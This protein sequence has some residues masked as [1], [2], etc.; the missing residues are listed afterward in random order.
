VETPWHFLRTEANDDLY[1][2][3]PDVYLCNQKLRV[4]RQVSIISIK[5]NN[6]PNHNQMQ[7]A[8]RE[9]EGANKRLIASIRNITMCTALTGFLGKEIQMN[10]FTSAPTVP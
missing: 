6:G 9:T 2:Q 1:R 10:F 8:S 5:S 3:H 4:T 7:A